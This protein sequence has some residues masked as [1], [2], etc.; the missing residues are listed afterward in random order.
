MGL[1]PKAIVATMLLVVE[2][3]ARGYQVLLSTHSPIVLDLMWAMRVVEKHAKGPEA[4]AKAFGVTAS[5]KQ[6]EVFKKCLA[7]RRSV[8]ALDYENKGVFS[9][10][11]SELDPQSADVAEHGWGGLTSF[12]T[13]VG[14][15]VAWS[16][17]EAR[18]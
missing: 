15:A 11:I 14:D 7:K 6:L 18:R 5:K 17:N 10:D 8:L 3:L 2:L 1:H 9:K 12:S 13:Q 16:V 4:L